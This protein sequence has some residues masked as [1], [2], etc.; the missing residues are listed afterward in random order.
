MAD[1]N[2]RERLSLYFN[3]KNEKEALMWECIDEKYSKSAFV[4][5]AIEEK[6]MRE[7]A[8]I[9]LNDL[10]KENSIESPKVEKETKP[11]IDKDKID[12][13]FVSL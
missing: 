10:I 8:G 7:K 3:T 13:N 11:K 12:T 5:E 2:G 6:I 4:K 9:N 1:K